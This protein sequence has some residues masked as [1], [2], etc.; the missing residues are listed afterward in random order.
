LLRDADGIISIG[1]FT[2]GEIQAMQQMPT[3]EEIERDYHAGYA[4]IMWFAEQ[5][6]LR[7]WRLTDRQLTHEIIQRERAAQ[8][9]EKSSLPIVDPAIRS[10]AYNRGQADAM[11]AI[12]REQREKQ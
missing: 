6:R 12:L 4:R 1:I 2:Q 10:A 8:I 3:K 7:G 11:R 9:R 5:A